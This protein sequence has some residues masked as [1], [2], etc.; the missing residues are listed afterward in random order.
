MNV[1]NKI[2]IKNKFQTNNIFSLFEICEKIFENN[3]LKYKYTFLDILLNEWYSI[4]KALI[5]DKINDLEN[6]NSLFIFNCHKNLIYSIIRISNKYKLKI[7]YKLF[8][9]YNQNLMKNKLIRLRSHIFNKLKKNINN[10]Y[11]KYLFFYYLINNNI[12]VLS[13]ENSIKKM[14]IIIKVNRENETISKINSFLYFIKWGIFVNKFN[15]IENDILFY[16]DKI[17]FFQIMAFIYIFKRWLRNIYNLFINKMMNKSY[18]YFVKKNA[19]KNNILLFTSL[20]LYNN[21]IIHNKI[22]FLKQIKSC[23]YLRISE[24]F[25]FY[26]CS[27]FINKILSRYKEKFMD[28]LILFIKKKRNKYYSFFHIISNYIYT[29]K[30]KSLIFSFYSIKSYKV[31]KLNTNNKKYTISKTNF[32]LLYDKKYSKILI[33]LINIYY[34]YHDFNN[35][36]KKQNR[37]FYFNK[38]KTITKLF[39]YQAIIQFN[40][41]IKKKF[42]NYNNTNIV[43]KNKLQILQKK[44][45]KKKINKNIKEKLKSNIKKYEKLKISEDIAKV[46]ND[47]NKINNNLD[48]L[49][50]TYLNNL[51]NLKIKNEGTI[52]EL[53]TQ[54]NDLIRE[55]ESLS[56]NI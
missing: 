5:T 29:K 12:R 27:L 14:E 54:I 40:N 13:K 2:Q 20:N 34:K 23:H 53:Q 19:I 52:N 56:A 39:Q 26:I 18:I 42:Q 25:L 10:I 17:K 49:R 33:N 28:K 32:E 3:I 9:L 46:I 1:K 4:N 41:Q 55:I 31:V 15:N 37:L 50:V 6:I 38:W 45:K 36:K 47:N 43:M 21:Y 44:N 11:L 24:T 30:Y 48:N 22:F 7:Y 8:F 51:E 35:W 16:L